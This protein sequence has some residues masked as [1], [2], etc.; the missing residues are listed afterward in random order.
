[1]PHRVVTDAGGTVW[2]VWSVTPDGVAG[3]PVLAVAPAYAAGW[4]AFE[5]LDAPAGATPEKRRL[6]PVP[7]GWAASDE[8]AVLALLAAAAPVTR[9]A[10]VAP[11]A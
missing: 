4:L 8:D 6:A 7:A 9:R 1:M 10:R 11:G 3:R 5:Q 2:Q